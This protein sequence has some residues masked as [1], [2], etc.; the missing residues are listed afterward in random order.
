MKSLRRRFIIALNG[1]YPG[2]IQS[3]VPLVNM[4]QGVSTPRYDEHAEI[5]NG[6][7]PAPCY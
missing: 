4:K 6:K 2:P 5:V 3:K 1:L 7:Y